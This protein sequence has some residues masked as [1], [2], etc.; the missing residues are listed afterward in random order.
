MDDLEA[1]VDDPDG[2]QLLSFVSSVHHQRVDQGLNNRALG[3]AEPLGGVTARAV[4]QKLAELLFDGDVI[5]EGHVRNV[6]LIAAPLSEEL[7]FRQLRRA[8]DVDHGATSGSGS[9]D[10]FVPIVAHDKRK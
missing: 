5:L 2:H 3:L 9:L 4:R 6:D 1:V 7:D 10:F 8:H